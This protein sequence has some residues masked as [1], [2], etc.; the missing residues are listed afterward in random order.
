M[1]IRPFSEIAITVMGIYFRLE[2]FVFVSIFGNGQGALQLMA[3]NYGANRSDRVKLVLKNALVITSVIMAISTVLFRLFPSLLLGPFNATEEMLLM[4]IPVFR[5]I[6]LCFIFAGITI[7]LFNA[8]QALGKGFYSHL[9][10]CFVSWRCCFR[11]HGSWLN[12]I[13]TMSG[14]HL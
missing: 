12:G 10:P 5:R 1:I 14:S 7:V 3:Y 11:S 2:C 13:L 9:S 8:F 4:G 6:F